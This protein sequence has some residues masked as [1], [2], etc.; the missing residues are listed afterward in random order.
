MVQIRMP[1]RAYY[2]RKIA[3]GATSRAA[4]RCL[5]RHLSNHIWRTVIT[6]GNRL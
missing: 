6:D 1:G 4:T 3:A 5:K 2:D